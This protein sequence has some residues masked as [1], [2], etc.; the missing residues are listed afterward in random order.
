MDQAR[1]QVGAAMASAPALPLVDKLAPYVTLSDAEI[2][3]LAELHEPQRKLAR[4]R[5]VIVAGRRYDQIFILCSGVVSRYKVL[6]DGKRQIL[7]LGLPG[8]LIGIPSCLFET[9]VNSVSAL[10]DI[11]VAPVSF[12]KLFDV[13]ARYPR[14]GVA[15]F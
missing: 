14:L 13:F 7:N 4:H 2:A 1:A 9:A 11:V 6:P 3:C 10:T 5:E 12:A 15:L 8:D